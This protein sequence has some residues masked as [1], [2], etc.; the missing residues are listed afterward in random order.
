MTLGYMRNLAR[1]HTFRDSCIK[2]TD[3][4]SYLMIQMP[5]PALDL[6][7]FH[8]R[9]PYFK[10][11]RISGESSESRRTACDCR[12]TCRIHPSTRSTSQSSKTKSNLRSFD[13][14]IHSLS[15]SAFSGRVEGPSS[16]PT[17]WGSYNPGNLDKSSCSYVS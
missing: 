14:S 13:T 1:S 2:V 8:P 16:Y 10:R 3:A 17:L 11:S 4:V 5:D 15:Q 9:W 12:Q 7:Q 6:A